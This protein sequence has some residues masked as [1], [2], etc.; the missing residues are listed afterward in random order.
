MPKSALVAIEQALVAADAILRHELDHARAKL[1]HVAMVMMRDGTVVMRGNCGPEVLT[2]FSEALQKIN[3]AR[4]PVTSP[5][6]VAMPAK[7]RS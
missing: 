7:A 6:K 5:S 1:P 3:R 4:L 2:E